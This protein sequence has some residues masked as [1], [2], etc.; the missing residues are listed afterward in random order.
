[1]K[2]PLIKL[3]THV[4]GS[5]MSNSPLEPFHLGV[6]FLL[7]NSEKHLLLLKRHH[8][9]KGIYWDLLVFTPISGSKA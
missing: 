7:F 4:L 3:S 8:P 5:E 2:Q 1:M 9:L 6:K